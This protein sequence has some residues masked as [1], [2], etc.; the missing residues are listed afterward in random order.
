MAKPYHYLKLPSSAVQQAAKGAVKLKRLVPPHVKAAQR[1]ALEHLRCILVDHCTEM[2]KLCMASVSREVAKVFSSA[3]RRSCVNQRVCWKG[4]QSA[5]FQP[6]MNGRKY[7]EQHGAGDDEPRAAV[8]AVASRP[9]SPTPAPLIVPSRPAAVVKPS[10]VAATAAEGGTEDA[11]RAAGHQDSCA[12]EAE[13]PLS[14]PAA[15]KAATAADAQQQQSPAK[16]VINA[17]R[18]AAVPAQEPAAPP[19]PPEAAAALRGR[20]GPPEQR[21][22]QLAAKDSTAPQQSAAVDDAALARHHDSLRQRIVREAERDIAQHMHPVVARDAGGPASGQADGVSRGRSADSVVRSWQRVLGSIAP[23]VYLNRFHSVA[24][25]LCAGSLAACSS[26][27]F[28]AHPLAP[29]TV[30][31]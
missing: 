16:E 15:A 25:Q 23:T 29:P 3:L 21:A 24:R 6:V 4:Y 20:A 31:S 7:Q 12:V 13:R 30:V 26:F 2:T 19:Q 27:L 11:C 14:R 10:A 22:L 5:V 28:H 18:Q 17:A 9:A 1:R 8:A